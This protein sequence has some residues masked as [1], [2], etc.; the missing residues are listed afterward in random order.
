MRAGSVPRRR[1]SRTSTETPG[2]DIELAIAAAAGRDHGAVGQTPHRVSLPGCYGTT[3]WHGDL[4]RDRFPG[5]LPA[6]EKI[7]N[8]AGPLRLFGG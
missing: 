5:I 7:K 6:S 1:W 2:A 8:P 3:N 4:L